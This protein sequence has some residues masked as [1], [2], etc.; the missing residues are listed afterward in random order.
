MGQYWPFS[1]NKNYY[2][3]LTHGFNGLGKDNCKM[4]RETCMSFNLVS[5]TRGL[6]VWV[7]Q[8]GHLNPLREQVIISIMTQKQ[9][10]L[11]CIEV[12][13]Y[14]LSC[15]IGTV[16]VSAAQSCNKCCSHFITCLINNMSASVQAWY[17]Q[18]ACHNL[19]KSWERSM[20]QS[21][22]HN[23]LNKFLQFRLLTKMT[24]STEWNDCIL[25]LPWILFFVDASVTL[26]IVKSK[27]PM[28]DWVHSEM[29][30]NTW[31]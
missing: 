15:G 21:P 5:Y 24:P 12:F 20:I 16:S 23:E 29:V 27:S 19:I 31:C 25:N 11:I 30:F 13:F 4:R 28:K 22:G 14:H 18:N 17:C 10:A 9:H 8:D 26:C 2:Y 1:V 7:K 6:T 3:Y